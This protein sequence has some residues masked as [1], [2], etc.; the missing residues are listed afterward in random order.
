MAPAPVGTDEQQIVAQI[1]LGQQA[2]QMLSSKGLMRVGSASDKDENGIT[3][4]LLGQ[5]ARDALREA[6]SLE[7]TIPMNQ[8]RIQVESGRTEASSTFPLEVRYTDK[9]GG[10]HTLSMNP[11]L[12]WRKEPVR[13]FL[14]FPGEEWQVVRAEGISGL[15]Q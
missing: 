11:A 5:Q 4:P 13:R 7:V 8:L 9:Q 15:T 6:Q 12:R 10:A 3:R 14:L 1:R 2:A